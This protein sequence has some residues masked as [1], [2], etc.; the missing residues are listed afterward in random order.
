MLAAW[1]VVKWAVVVRPV[2]TAC[3][4]DAQR[5]TLM[6]HLMNQTDFFLETSKNTRFF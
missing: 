2:A 5:Q 1:G 6:S 4:P 3:R